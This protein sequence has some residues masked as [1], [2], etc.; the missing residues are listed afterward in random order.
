MGAMDRRQFMAAA[1]GGALGMFALSDAALA[2]AVVGQTNPGGGVHQVKP[3]KFAPD[4]LK[5]ISQ[6]LIELHHG[7]HYAG[8][9]RKRNELE[10]Q[11]TRV[12]PG[13]PDFDPR[14]FAGVK[15]DESWNASGMILH[16]VYFD[17]LGGDGQPGEGVV[18]QQIRASFGTIE[19][20][21]ADMK[22]IG[23]GATGWALTCYD[24]SD[25]RV[26][27]YLV[28]QHQFGAVWGAIPLIALDVFEHAY[29]L[30]Y[31]P[32]RASYMDAFFANLHWGRINERY[33]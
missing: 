16:E 8:Y 25:G 29:Y 18:E 24:P 1:G 7:R 23:S 28:D 20:W 27:N 17:N 2:G 11:L 14:L 9:V 33:G 5:G 19:Q 10:A 21:M 22:A 13:G 4:S 6:K 12:G 3:L 31:G 32:D 15:R 26:H 30:D